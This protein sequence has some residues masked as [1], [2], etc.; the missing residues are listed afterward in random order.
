MGAQNL[1][2]WREE[3]TQQSQAYNN[4]TPTTFVFYHL[5]CIYMK[6]SDGQY[7]E[8]PQLNKGVTTEKFLEQVLAAAS[9]CR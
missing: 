6:C 5:P 2:S 8:S 1:R 4:R 7:F 3:E 9:I